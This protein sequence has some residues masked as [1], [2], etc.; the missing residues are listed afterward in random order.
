MED[1]WTGIAAFLGALLG[2]GGTMLASR[3]RTRSEDTARRWALKRE[4]YFDV[5]DAIEAHQDSM[6]KIIRASESEHDNAG[7]F[8]TFF[9]ALVDDLL[10]KTRTLSAMRA[11]CIVV[12][13]VPVANLLDEMTDLHRAHLP[14]AVSADQFRVLYERL[15]RVM[16]EEI[17]ATKN[18]NT[19]APAPMPAQFCGH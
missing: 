10:A 12:G 13:G 19:K 9:S 2:A 5:L 16:N 18:P 4:I 3:H 15:L 8:D 7:D 14:S 1:L 6:W 17:G 11:R